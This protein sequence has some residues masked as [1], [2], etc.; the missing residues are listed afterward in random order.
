M[1][2]NVDP[3]SGIPVPLD[4]EPNS[5]HKIEAAYSNL[6]KYLNELTRP[7]GLC[8][9]QELFVNDNRE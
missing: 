3:E 5:S 6:Q 4:Y 7:E 8:I 2:V 9:S 1:L